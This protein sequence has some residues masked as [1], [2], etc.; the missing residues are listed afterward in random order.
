V[1]STIGG[2]GRLQDGPTASRPTY[3]LIQVLRAI[4]ALMVVAHHTTLML[5]DR[6]GL[7]VANWIN[8]GAG[9]DIF[10]VVSGFVMT[11]SSAPLRGST[12]PAR[13]FLARRIE[14]IAPMYWIATTVKLMTVLIAPA[15]ALNALGTPWH[16]IASYLFLPSRN[17]HGLI[18]PILVVGWTLNYEMAFY[19]LFAVALAT[20]ASLLKVLAPVLIL[21]ALLWVV[22]QHGVP[23]AV[24]WYETPMVLEFLAGIVLAR[25]LPRIKRLAAPVALLLVIAGFTGLLTMAWPNFSVWRGVGWGLPAIAIVCGALA[26]EKRWGAKT[27]RWL[28][29]VGDASYSIYL[30]HG[31]ALP[32][33]GVFL[34]RFGSQW[35]GVVPVSLAAAVILSTIAGMVVYRLV[36]RPIANWFKGR[37]RTA[38]PVNA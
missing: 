32:V 33:I 24:R 11:I 15:L 9:V 8:G 31:F 12:H 34:S 6:N 13:T 22:P 28:L 36:E 14:R 38:V 10:F 5:H 1:S 30:V 35:R 23:D 4:A 2:A 20:R 18:E 3:H 27:P 16:V 19:V 7:P 17:A 29:E 26:L 25:V 21:L 37:R